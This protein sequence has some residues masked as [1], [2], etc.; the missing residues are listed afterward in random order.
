MDKIKQ[1]FS[2]FK[3]VISLACCL[4]CMWV[5]WPLLTGLFYGMLQARA[6][7]AVAAGATGLAVAANSPPAYYAAPAAAA[8]AA[9]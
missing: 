6:A 9:M 2:R 7:S 1:L 3:L 4:V 8:A 5:L